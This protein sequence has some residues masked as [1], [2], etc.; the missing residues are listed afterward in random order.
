MSNLQYSEN[1]SGLGVTVHHVNLA[2]GLSPHHTLQI[3]QLMNRYRVVIFPNQKLTDE[4]LFNFAFRFGPPFVPD[5]SFPVLGSAEGESALVIIGNQAN[6]YSNSYLG[7]QEVLP[8]SDHQWLRCP[9]SASLLYAVDITE[10]S[11]PTIWT[12]MARAYTLLDRETRNIIQD[13]RLIT[14]NPFYRPFG[15]VSAK[16]V[17][18]R[19][20][21]PSGETFP[22]PLVRTHPETREKI[23]FLN[24]AY[25]IELVG[26]S[27]DVGAQ[28]IARL[29]RHI[30][31]LE[32]RYEHLWQNGDVVLWDNQATL[33]YRPAFDPK[34][35]RV[36]KRVTIGGGI[37]F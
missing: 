18:R 21:T 36:L 29:H 4:H 24:A 35:R 31:E 2:A 6:D 10:N 30:Q 32:C 5:K 15:S 25:E 12:D 16:Y 8:H 3:R 23:L 13:L 17:D 7:F 26:I 1:E 19:V 37:P 11:S 20:E 33:H 9:S 27:Y 34:V 28:L 14:Y 22:H